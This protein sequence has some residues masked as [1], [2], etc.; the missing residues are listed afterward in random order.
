MFAVT[1]EDSVSLFRLRKLFAIMHIPAVRKI[2]GPYAIMEGVP[3][4]YVIDRSGHIR[5]AKAAAFDLDSLNVTTV[6]AVE[7]TR[8]ARDASGRA[9]S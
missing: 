9:R 5:Y 8:S 2:H 3:T 4:N 7:G 1:T 6:A